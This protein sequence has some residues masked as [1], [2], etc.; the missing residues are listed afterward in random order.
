VLAREAPA[1]FENERNMPITAEQRER[2]KLAIG[3]SDAAAILGLSPY[4]TRYDVY[5]EKTGLLVEE[6]E[7]GPA[8]EAGTMFQDGV[9]NWA[10]RSLGK[11]KRDVTIPAPD[12]LP[13]VA[14]VDAIVEADGSPAEAKTAGLFSPLN[15][16][17]GEEGTDQVPAPYIVQTHI[18]MLVTKKSTCHLPAFLAGR[19]FVMFEVALDRELMS[20]MIARCEDFWNEN[21]LKRVPPDDS[22]LS[23]GVAKRLKRTPSKTVPVD[24]AVVAAWMKA[25][26]ERLSAE[27][28][29]KAA[30]AALLT[31]LGDAEAGESELGI[32]TYN[33]TERKA[34]EVKA[35]S[36]R[37]LRIKK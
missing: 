13:I 34:Y 20:L 21:V 14:N 10:E 8:A 16:E 23:L 29:D 18:H 30:Q 32:V 25:R 31:A 9:L 1:L 15:E 17:W 3:S 24:A 35:T 7:A 36:F 28:A 27:K 37:T 26:D 19:G 2:R 12:G 5:A 22:I 4:K 11:L 33:L 6:A